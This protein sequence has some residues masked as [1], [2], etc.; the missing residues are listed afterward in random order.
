[1]PRP[2][3]LALVVLAALSAC[4]VSKHAEVC[5]PANDGKVVTVIGYVTVGGFSLVSSDNT[6][7]IKI[8]ESTK[9]EQSIRVSVQ[10]GTGPNTMKQLPEGDFKADDVEITLGDGAKKGVGDRIAVTGKL[11]VNGDTCA[12]YEVDELKAP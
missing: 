7:P 11:T 10:Q 6:F 2:R 9:A 4:E 12:I 1:V 8:A 3:L 5:V